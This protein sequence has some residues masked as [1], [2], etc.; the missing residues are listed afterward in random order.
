[1]DPWIAEERKRA[2]G[3][4]HEYINSDSEK[5]HK[6]RKGKARHPLSLFLSFCCVD[7]SLSP[8]GLLS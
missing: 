4:S 5:H 6:K 3:K 8:L 2:S 7:I 1:V